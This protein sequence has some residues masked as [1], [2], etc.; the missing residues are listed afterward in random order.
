MEPTPPALGAQSLSHWNTKEVQKD[1]FLNP[2]SI[3]SHLLRL[4]L[5]SFQEEDRMMLLFVHI[6][7]MIQVQKSCL[8]LQQLL[9]LP[10]QLEVVTAAIY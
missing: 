10:P 1:L 6:Q 9:H 7:K 2:L 5:D 3:S 8:M 4:H